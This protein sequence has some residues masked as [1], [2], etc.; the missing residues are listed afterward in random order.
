MLLLWGKLDSC[1][2][3]F[4]RCIRYLRCVEVPNRCVSQVRLGMQGNDEGWGLVG[5]DQRRMRS[6]VPFPPPL[7]AAHC[8]L[9][10]WPGRLLG[11]DPASLHSR[12]V[13]DLSVLRYL[14]PVRALAVQPGTASGHLKALCRAGSSTVDD[15]YYHT[16][17]MRTS[18][19]LLPQQ[20]LAALKL[21][22]PMMPANPA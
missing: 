17:S 13:T 15:T 5:L 1:R 19:Y 11:T 10:T 4:G 2:T 22:W 14:H 16:L 20:L 3:V 9:P 12:A 7:S 18:K 21:P 6:H 8:P